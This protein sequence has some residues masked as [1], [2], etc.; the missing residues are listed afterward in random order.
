ME[1]LRDTP[2]LWEGRRRR[3]IDEVDVLMGVSGGSLLASYFALHGSSGLDGFVTDVLHANLQDDFIAR[4]LQPHNLW[5]LQSPRFGRGDLLAEYLDERVFHGATFADLSRAPHKPHI[6]IYAADMITGERFEFVQD[7]FDLICSNLDRLKLARAVAASAAVPLIFS[8]ITLWNHAAQADTAGCGELSDPP[9]QGVDSLP[10]TDRPYIHLLDGG[11]ADN[12]GARGP[13]DFSSRFGGVIAG[14]RAAGLK[15][16]RRIVYLVVNAETRTFGLSDGSAD[17]PNPVRTSLALAD[18]PINRNS[19]TALV[20]QEQ[21]LDSWRAEVRIAHERNEFVEFGADAEFYLIHIN[22]GSS[23]N[24][25]VRKRLQAIP[26]SL[27]LP[28]DDVAL[29][30]AQGRDALRRSPEFQR[31]LR[32]L[33]R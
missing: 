12:V 31:L 16:L 25:T 27:K 13:V 10:L 11:L 8:P 26:T 15:G 7:Q 4:V 9:M 23:D 19:K 17:I 20:A 21:L 2:V 6:I 1:E 24:P 3:L 22:I 32:E 28:E 33:D 18:I 30:R 5:R 29:L 14:A